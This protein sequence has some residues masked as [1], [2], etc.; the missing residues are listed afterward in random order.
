MASEDILI[1][2]MHIIND[3][4]VSL[5][6]KKGVRAA[7]STVLLSSNLKIPVILHT[8]PLCSLQPEACSLQRGEVS[9]S[10]RL[11]AMCLSELDTQKQSLPAAGT[12]TGRRGTV[13]PPRSLTR[14][15]MP[16]FRPT[17]PSECRSLNL[18]NPAL[19]QLA[20]VGAN[21]ITG[22]STKGVGNINKRQLGFFFLNWTFT[23]LI[24]V[25]RQQCDVFFPPN[26]YSNEYVLE[27]NRKW[28]HPSQLPYWQNGG[29]GSTLCPAH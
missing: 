7:D 28:V 21:Q 26:D 10:L 8:E 3:L 13:K 4:W 24:T 5:Y 25:Y 19:E 17:M 27:V 18:F 6:K 12:H 22:S 29:G 11:A 16:F 2:Y 14:V 9:P 1:Y 15:I 20:E 23:H